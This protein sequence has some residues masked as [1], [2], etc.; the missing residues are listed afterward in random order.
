MLQVRIGTSRLE[1]ADIPELATTLVFTSGR[2]DQSCPFPAT[3]PSVAVL[4]VA[5]N[6]FEAFF[7]M[8]PLEGCNSAGSV[9]QEMPY[10]T[11]SAAK[12]CAYC[13]HC[14]TVS[15]KLR[16]MNDAPYGALPAVIGMLMQTNAHVMGLQF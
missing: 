4:F 15:A 12:E 3:S 11:V 2:K 6:Q 13:V 14:H 9:D 7:R 8:G 10:V 1:E 16:G 5:L